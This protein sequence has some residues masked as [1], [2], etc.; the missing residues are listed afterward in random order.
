MSPPV[1]IDP[2]AK[3]KYVG[4]RP[5]NDQNNPTRFKLLDIIKHVGCFYEI[6]PERLYLVYL[7]K[8]ESMDDFLNQ[9]DGSSPF[10]FWSARNNP[11][12]FY[13]SFNM[14]FGP[15]NLAVTHS[16][17]SK[18]K[19]WLDTQPYRSPDKII[20]IVLD[21]EDTERK[22]NI[23]LAVAIASMV[24]LNLTD[25]EV[26]ERLGFFMMYS[27]LINE[28]GKQLVFHEKK[29]FNDVSGNQSFMSITLA[30]CIKAFHAA[31]H[32]KFYDYY[33]FDQLEYL[34]FETIVSGDLN[35]IIPGKLLA[36]AG[37]VDRP[38]ASR[39]TPDF[40]YHYFKDHG[41]SSI[42]RL[43]EPEY[44]GEI[45]KKLGFDHHDLIFPDGYPPTTTIAEKFIK[46]VDEAK[47][48]V[49]VH[50]YAGI[51]RTGTLIAAYL[52]ARYN[53]TAYMAVAWTRICRP[54]SVIGEQQDWL[55]FKFN[56]Y[57]DT[58][59]PSKPAKSRKTKLRDTSGV[60]EIINEFDRSE[61]RQTRTSYAE[62][63]KTYGQ[64]RALIMTKN[65]RDLEL[66][67]RPQTRDFDRKRTTRQ[68]VKRSSLD[69][70]D[71]YPSTLKQT[72]TAE[73]LILDLG[74]TVPWA[75]Y[76]D[77]I[78]PLQGKRNPDVYRIRDGKY[79]WKVK[80][81]KSDYVDFRHSLNSDLSEDLSMESDE[82]LEV[83]RVSLRFMYENDEYP[84][85]KSAAKKKNKDFITE[86][87]SAK[88]QASR[89]RPLILYALSIILC[90]IGL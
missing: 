81:P 75:L 72:R 4:H 90:F 6:S 58:I 1:D 9:V 87:D 51:G 16:F 65:Q 41:V 55:L 24:L 64:A 18:L 70:Q 37:P 21:N 26:L 57:K 83:R 40:Y 53:F 17:C 60:P 42:I 84:S 67:N 14:D 73:N 69:T 45:F 12:L 59:S 71:A 68:A 89:L 3:L 54:G 7:A 33:E 20:A 32:F 23:T 76:K 62:A 13:E 22:L 31:L 34:F 85:K 47:G 46:I 30:D 56:Q 63:E 35:W 8:D 27:G 39:R 2:K 11:E 77:D 25:E 52:M 80:F 74:K 19:V 36:F 48:A 5:K 61:D 29:K 66:T 44:S 38:D 28:Q 10:I 43:N 88:V 86:V 78:F 50:C 82:D 79:E 15:F 49:A